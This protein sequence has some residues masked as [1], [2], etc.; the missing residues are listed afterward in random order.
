MKIKSILRHQVAKG[1][2]YST[3]FNFTGATETGFKFTTPTMRLINCKPIY[4][5]PGLN[6]SIPADWNLKKFFEKIGGDCHEHVSKFESIKEIF[7][8]SNTEYLCKKGLPVKQRKYLLR[9]IELLRRGLLTFEYLERRK[10]VVQ[11]RKLTKP[12]EK[13]SIKKKS[14]EDG[15]KS[16]TAA[17]ASGQKK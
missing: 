3:K 4:P 6:L 15:P 13:T 11:C 10:Q 9:T 5:A 1:L 16:K 17:T 8:N 2:I 12:V 14:V 7:D